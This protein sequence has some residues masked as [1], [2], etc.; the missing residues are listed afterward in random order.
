VAVAEVLL[1]VAGVDV[2]PVDVRGETPLDQLAM[3]EADQMEKRILTAAGTPIAKEMA[4]LRPRDD[5]GAYIIH[6]RLEAMRKL[7]LKYGAVS[8]EVLK[9]HSSAS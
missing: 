1:E 3:H 4:R 2:N 9:K 6:E 7:L 8:G 5:L